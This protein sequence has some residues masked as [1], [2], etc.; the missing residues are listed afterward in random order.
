MA[1]NI[2][3]IDFGSSKAPENFVNSL[4]DTG[5]AV[6]RNHSIDFKL[7]DNVYEQWEQF[8]DSKDKY[9]YMFDLEK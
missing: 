3:T 4:I 8:F 9:D 7:I 5:F 6:I 1:S 2:K